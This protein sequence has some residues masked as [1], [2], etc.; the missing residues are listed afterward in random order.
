MVSRSMRERLNNQR[1][2]AQYPKVCTLK[3]YLQKTSKNSTPVTASTKGQR[4]EIRLLQR[5]QSPS[6]PTTVPP[7]NQP[8]QPARFC[9]YQGVAHRNSASTVAAA[10]FQPHPA[11]DRYILPL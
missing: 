5:R 3:P 8:R 2:K 7:K 11:Q 4:T 1:K 10:P 6:H 9:L